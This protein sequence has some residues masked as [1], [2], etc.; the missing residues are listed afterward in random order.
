[1]D[2]DEQFLRAVDFKVCINAFNIS[3]FFSFFFP[4]LIFGVLVWLCFFLIHFRTTRY[5]D[6]RPVNSLV[7]ALFQFCLISFRV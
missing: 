2:L 1:M 3:A 6:G 5:P 7:K 4:K